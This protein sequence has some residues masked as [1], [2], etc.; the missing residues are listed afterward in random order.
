MRIK[1]NILILFISLLPTTKACA[2]LCIKKS[3][4]NVITTTRSTSLYRDV[5][6]IGNEHC[7]I[8]YKTNKKANTTEEEVKQVKKLLILSEA[9]A[10]KNKKAEALLEQHEAMQQ[11]RSNTTKTQKKSYRAHFGNAFNY[12]DKE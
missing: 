4:R 5:T 10:C 11:S 3:P 7:F 2:M 1:N 12:P 6:N 8:A 9:I